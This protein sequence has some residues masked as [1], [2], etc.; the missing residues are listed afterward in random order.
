MY[1]TFASAS[2]VTLVANGDFNNGTTGW[3]AG[4]TATLT[5]SSNVLSVSGSG[6][7]AFPLAYKTLSLSGVKRIFVRA[8]IRVTNASCQS[9]RVRVY[10][11]S[12][13]IDTIQS[14]PINGTWYTVSGVVSTTFSGSP[15]I[16]IHSTYADAATANGKVMEVQEVVCIDVTE[17]GKPACVFDGTNDCL[18][19]SDNASLQLTTRLSINAVN[20]PNNTMTISVGYLIA[21]NGS[22]SVEVQ[23]GLNYDI[24]TTPKPAAYHF[25]LDGA[26]RESNAGSSSPSLETHIVT[27]VWNG[28]NCEVF[29][30]GVSDGATA[31]AGTLTNRANTFVGC[32]SNSADGTAQSVHFRGN[33]SEIILFNT[34]LTNAQR[35][36]LER[37]QGR[38]YG[39]TVT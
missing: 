5:A 29:G 28:A 16:A 32:R 1:P 10:D 25:Y 15:N 12:T 9:I 6:S 27:A 34:T 3:G 13:T 2:G 37:N 11:G 31:Y 18:R 30:D 33:I 19:I 23:Y 4:T 21:R 35:Q 26:D 24:A 39:V 36:K 38:Y 7:T 22:S 8:T 17:L 14:S 20:N